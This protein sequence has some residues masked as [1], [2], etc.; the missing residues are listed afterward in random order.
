MEMFLIRLIHLKSMKNTSDNNHE[1][2]HQTNEKI[3]EKSISQRKDDE[4][5]FGLKDKIETIGQMK[6]LLK[7]KMQH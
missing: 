4:D 6:I 1:N 5:F 3:S 7:R 2:L